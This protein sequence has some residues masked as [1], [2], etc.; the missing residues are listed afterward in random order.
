MGL[1]LP[2]SDKKT[3]GLFLPVVLALVTQYSVLA[4]RNTKEWERC[5]RVAG[6]EAGYGAK[7]NWVDV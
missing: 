3:M 7:I 4:T 2:F 1:G 6:N 5:G